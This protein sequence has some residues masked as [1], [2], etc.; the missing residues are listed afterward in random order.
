[1]KSPYGMRPA[2][3]YEIKTAAV[4]AL[5]P[6]FG[7]RDEKTYRETPPKPEPLTE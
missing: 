6:Q 4:L 3:P 7:A 2:F 5:V 1:M